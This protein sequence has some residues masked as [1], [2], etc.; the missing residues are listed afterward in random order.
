M[1]PNSCLRSLECF[2]PKYDIISIQF[3]VLSFQASASNGAKW[4]Q[5]FHMDYI[6]LT[7][8]LS[9]FL[10][11]HI[12]SFQSRQ[13]GIVVIAKA[14]VAS[15]KTWKCIIHLILWFF[16]FLVCHSIHMWIVVLQS[17]RVK[18]WCK[19]YHRSGFMSPCSTWNTFGC[20]ESI[21]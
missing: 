21:Q 17:M 16:G 8:S 6:S 10:S 3:S 9:L 19:S 5:Q 4:K 7:F 1:H 12:S 2:I 20:I 11:R 18:F 14:N 15:Q 13:F